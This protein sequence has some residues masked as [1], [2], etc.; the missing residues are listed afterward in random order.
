MI[1]DG[2]TVKVGSFRESFQKLFWIYTIH[3]IHIFMHCQTIAVLS[4]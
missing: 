1:S 2:M 3:K 4:L